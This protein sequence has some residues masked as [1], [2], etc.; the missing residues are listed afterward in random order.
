MIPAWGVGSVAVAGTIGYCSYGML[1]PN[2]SLF[3]PVI[4]RGPRDGNAIY[5]T[6]DDGPGPTATERILSTLEDRDVPA[7]FFVVGRHVRLHPRLAARLG[8]TA[9]EIGNHTQRHTKLHLKSRRFIEGELRAAHAAIEDVVGRAP[10]AFRAPHGY[11]NAAV[12]RVA[13]ELR[14]EVFGWTLGVWD[15]DRPGAEEIRRRVR[16]GLAPGTIILLHDGDGYDPE[17]DRAQ[18]AEAL[19]GIIRDARDEGYEFRPLSELMTRV[20]REERVPC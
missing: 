7:A 18:T 11:K 8:R 12:H 2:S 1:S 14:Y 4:G 20:T 9:H 13:R 16:R 6:F 3:G 10:R 19:D 15:T 17:G 5:L